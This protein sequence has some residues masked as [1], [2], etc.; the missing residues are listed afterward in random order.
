MSDVAFYIVST[1]LIVGLTALN[2]HMSRTKRLR[3]IMRRGSDG[4]GS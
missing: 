3:R 1:L 4:A 2:W